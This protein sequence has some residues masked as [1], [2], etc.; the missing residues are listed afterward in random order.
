[1]GKITVDLSYDFLTVNNY[2]QDISIDFAPVKSLCDAVKYLIPNVNENVY[3]MFCANDDLADKKVLIIA[4]KLAKAI[5]KN[6]VEEVKALKKEYE[7][8]IEFAKA[9]KYLDQ[10]CKEVWNVYETK[11]VTVPYAAMKTLGITNRPSIDFL[12][13]ESVKYFENDNGTTTVDIIKSVLKNK[14]LDYTIG[15]IHD[16]LVCMNKK[17]KCKYNFNT[18]K[19]LIENHNYNSVQLS[20]LGFNKDE[21]ANIF[22][23]LGFKNK[24]KFIVMNTKNQITVLSNTLAKS[25]CILLKK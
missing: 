8:D 9:K 1:M 3:F 2:V 22:K 4:Q 13:K 16:Y 7:N 17:E 20:E 15:D 25:F 11:N 5:D 10:K 18:V 23:K 6:S 19:Y 21:L 12:L 24:V 14:K